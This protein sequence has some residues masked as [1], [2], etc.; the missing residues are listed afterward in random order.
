MATLK[1]NDI[2]KIVEDASYRQFASYLSSSRVCFNTLCFTASLVGNFIPESPDKLMA[3]L[4]GA[5]FVNLGNSVIKS[6]IET[7]KF[8]RRYR[9]ELISKTKEYKECKNLYDNYIK[10]IAMFMR[11]IGVD[12]SLDV[13]MLYMEMLYG[14][15]LS[16]PGTFKYHK[17][18]IDNDYC[19]PVM[20]AR[21]TSGQAV[22]RHIAS[23]LVD[24]YREL[25]FTAAYVSVK[26]IKNDIRSVIREKILPFKSDHAVVMVGDNYGKYIIDPTWGT[27]AVLNNTDEFARIIFNKKS[28]TLY[29]LD[30]NKTV[31]YERTELDDLSRLRKVKNAS[32]KPGEIKE[33]FEYAQRYALDNISCLNI[34]S[35]YLSRN[36]DEIAELEY[37]LSCYSDNY[38]NRCRKSLIKR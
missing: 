36:M 10:T 22:C 11:S 29:H 26:G 5:T 25:G 17:Y 7:A 27:V 2:D 1:L 18:A 20:G 16:A 30:L 24:L 33:S 3:F 35:D 4:T 38:Y 34:F 37:R 13:G 9:M 19:S 21:I 8:V 31:E 15:F 23:S 14:G 32:F 28:P 6:Y 12:D